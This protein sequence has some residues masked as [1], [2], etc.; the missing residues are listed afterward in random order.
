MKKFLF[1]LTLVAAV[2]SA[3]FAAPELT[4]I[5]ASNATDLANPYSHGLDKF[6]EVAE[7]VSGGK[8]AVT[9]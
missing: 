1:A 4:L 3:S 8:I 7:Q 6:K 5:I 9:V 2:A